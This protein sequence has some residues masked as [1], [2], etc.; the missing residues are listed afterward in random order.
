MVTTAGQPAVKKAAP[1]AIR[2]QGTAWLSADR[3]RDDFLCLWYG[4]PNDGRLLEQARAPTAA[5]AVAWGAYRSSRVR[6]RTDEGRTYWAGTAPRPEGFS[7]T[8]VAAEGPLL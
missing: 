5:A 2:Q 8:W 6:I 1:A 4:G 7:H 3:L